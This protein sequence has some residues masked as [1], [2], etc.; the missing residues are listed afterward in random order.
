MGRR[1]LY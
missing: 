1:W